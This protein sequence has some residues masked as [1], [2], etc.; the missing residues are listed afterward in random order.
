MSL[1]VVPIELKEANA[2]IAA[3]HR[4]HQPVI[5][6]RFSIGVVDDDGVLHGVCVVGRPV[7]RLAGHPRDVAEVTRLA[8]DGSDNACSMLY[9][10]AARAAKAMGFRRI[11]T[12]TLPSEGGA[13]LRA[14][15]WV[16]EGAAGGGQWKHTD[17]KPRRT[18]Q[19]TDIKTRW[20][21]T[22]ARPNLVV[23]LPLEILASDEQQMLMCEPNEGESPNNGK[24]TAA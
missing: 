9:G 21:K 22:F 11:Q 14:S 18:D 23:S 3:M 7:A 16:D 5:G 19:P 8:T 2:F 15:G 10:S 12:Y 4:H 17:G 20:A 24:G 6:H 13:S 1:H